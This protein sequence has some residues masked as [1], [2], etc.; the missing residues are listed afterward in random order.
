MGL[1]IHS[2]VHMKLRDVLLAQPDY[3]NDGPG[4]IFPWQEPPYAAPSAPP[5]LGAPPQQP[6]ALGVAELLKARFRPPPT[7]GKKHKEFRWITT[8]LTSDPT[9]DTSPRFID[10][11]ASSSLFV[12]VDILT[13]HDGIRHSGLEGQ[14][15]LSPEP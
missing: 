2:E 12:A 9:E 14:S 4:A 7:G 5:G 10:W 11:E 13:H 6:T 3:Q 8:S 15:S 1:Y